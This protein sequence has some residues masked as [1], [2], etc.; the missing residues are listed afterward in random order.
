MRAATATG[1]I[2]ALWSSSGPRPR[3]F[4]WGG[5][6]FPLTGG[7]A[8]PLL[9]RGEDLQ[10]RPGREPPPPL[11]GRGEEAEKACPRGGP[12]G[13]P[14]GP[15]PGRGPPAGRKEAGGGAP[16]DPRGPP[17]PHAL[18]Q[19]LRLAREHPSPD[20][21]LSVVL[22]ATT[23]CT[24]NRC[25][26]C[27]FYQ[28]RPFQKRTPE[29]FRE[30]IQAVLALLGRG[31]LL[32]RGVFLA[33]G[34]A[35]ALSEPLLPLLELVRAHFPGEPVMGFL[36]LFT[37]LKKAPSWWER[38]GGMGLRRVYIGLETGHAPSSPSSGSPATPRRSCP[39]SGR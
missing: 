36:D 5:G 23:G 33:D 35:L 34:N 15:G 22:Q 11:P 17:G 28:D 2:L 18:P 39:W 19:G 12:W 20:A 25:A 38:L 10:A 9:P 7:K 16:L 4:P 14:G 27:S 8:L 37:G 29:A 31:R 13:L 32:R 24:W 3:S 26:F 1:L 21:Y 30:H 6:S